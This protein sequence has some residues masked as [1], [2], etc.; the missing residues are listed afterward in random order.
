MTESKKTVPVK[1]VILAFLFIV[2]LPL[3]PFFISGQ[4]DWW[5]VWLY[6]G[7]SVVSFIV[8]RVIAGKKN[9]GLLEERSKYT[10]QEDAESWDKVLSPLVG[11]GGVL[12]LIV[13]GLDARFDWTASLS[14]TLRLVGFGVYLAGHFLGGYALVENA[15]F[16]GMVRLQEERGHHVIDT[17]P[18]AWVRHPGYTG[19]LLTYVGTPLLLNSWWG[20]IPTAFMFAVLILRTAKE[21][22]FLQENLEGYR[23]FTQKTKYRLFPYIW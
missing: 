15:F 7:T 9:P 23:D 11:F 1:A 4:W 12:I 16:S 10:S 14:L 19:A 17:G 8:S 22:R 21:D 3:L 5:E 13:A 6:A 20:F 2:V 18:Y